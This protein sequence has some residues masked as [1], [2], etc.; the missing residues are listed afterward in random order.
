MS[1]QK[2]ARELKLDLRMFEV[3]A[4]EHF[5]QAF[6]KAARTAVQVMIVPPSSMFNANQK[7]IIDLAAKYKLPTVYGSTAWVESGGLASYGSNLSKLRRDAARYVDRILRGAKPAD[8]PIEQPN[9]VELAVN[10]KTARALGLKIPEV[11]LLRADK[12]LE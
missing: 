2:P 8:L 3:H 5:E 4:T 12:V 1:S 7:H 10:L 11:V 9:T 6:D